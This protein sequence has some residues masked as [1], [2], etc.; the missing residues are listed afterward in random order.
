M[1]T[2]FV[3]L[4][5]FSWSCIGCLSASSHGA[6][7]AACLPLLMELHWLP[8]CLFSWSCIGC[9]SASSHG[10]ALAACLPKGPVQAKV[11]L[12]NK[13]NNNANACAAALT[14]SLTLPSTRHSLTSLQS[15]S[16]LCCPHQV[17]TQGEREILCRFRPSF[18]SVYYACSCMR[19]NERP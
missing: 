10:A 14:R 17:P 12:H 15:M 8:V 5:L 9:L 11:P 1:L 6:A 2:S 7:L 19:Y 4:P 18:W 13:N 16:I 3:T